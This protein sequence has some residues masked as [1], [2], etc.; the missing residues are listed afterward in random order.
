MLLALFSCRPG[1]FGDFGHFK[2]DF[3]LNDFQ[4][5]DIRRAQMPRILD[6]RAAQGPRT[7]VQLPHTA[8]DQVNQNVGVANFLQCFSSQFSVQSVVQGIR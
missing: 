8:R 5:R 1:Q 7:G 2:A 4:K 6:Q 3:I